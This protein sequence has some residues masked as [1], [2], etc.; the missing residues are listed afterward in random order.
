M[1]KL[2]GSKG[3]KELAVVITCEH[4]GHHVPNRYR[5]YFAGA[6]ATLVSHRG[7]D[8]GALKL[9]RKF[10]SEIGA[11]L[12]SSTV[13]R[14]L[15]ELNRSLNHRK[16]FSEFTESLHVEEKERLLADVWHPYRDK[17]RHAIRE[18]I[19]TAG[20]VVH[21]SVHTFTPLWN[22]EF[23]KTDVGLLYDPQRHTEREFCHR[24]G[25]AIS[26]VEPEL[27]VHRNAPYRGTSD[28]FVTGLRREFPNDV[29][30]GLELEVNQKYFMHSQPE[31]RSGFRSLI[32]GFN[33]TLGA[34]K[35]ESRAPM[36][37]CR[38]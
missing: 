30:T 28:G 9:A 18:L 22:G 6:E 29:Y 1:K 13:T 15:V 35:S 4:G 2:T 12:F 34:F 19:D 10:A 33:Q 17:V 26:V 32:S 37:G 25:R 16:L 20:S 23:R 38:Q 11:P 27:I 14:L 8:P 31:Y 36:T 3:Q 5:E 24:W 7:W 21:L